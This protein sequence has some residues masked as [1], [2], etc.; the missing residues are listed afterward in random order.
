VETAFDSRVERD[1][2]ARSLAASTFGSMWLDIP[3][4]DYP[5]LTGPVTCDLLVVGGGYTGLWTALHAAKRNPDQSIVLI[6]ANRI[7]W[8]AS[9]RNGGFVDASLT[10]GAENGSRAGPMRLTRCTLDALG[11]GFD[12]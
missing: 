6:E 7:G 5:P 2:V 8:A 11:L 1:L 4:P 9:G 12:S 3:M 10:H